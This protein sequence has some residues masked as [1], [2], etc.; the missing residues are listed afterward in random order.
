M[1]S[2][3]EGHAGATG[4][5]DLSTGAAMTV[6]GVARRLGVAPATLRTWDRRYGLGPTDH[7]AGAHRRYSPADVARLEVMR[8]LVIEGAAPVDAA[9]VAL[10]GVAMETPTAPD[11]APGRGGGGQVVP[12][13]GGSAAARGLARA[14]MSLDAPAVAAIV[15]SN[16][17]RRGVIATWDDLL[18]PV[19]KGVGSRFE[20]TGRGVEVEHLLSEAVMAA[21]TEV[22]RRMTRP[23]NHQPVLL[24]A[25]DEEQHTLPLHAVAAA[26]AEQRVASRMLGAR[27]PRGALAAAVRRS[28]PIAVMVWSQ[29]PGD[30]DARRRQLADLPSI[31]PAPLVVVGGP[32]WGDDD[33]PSGVTFVHTLSDAV[34]RLVAA[35]LV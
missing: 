10:A 9:R 20:W 1:S 17:E 31:R 6:A 11:D 7:A 22:T 16:I 29:L 3:S 15:S 32:G 19:L 35:T 12:L 34:S 27:V 4:P 2:S 13:P 25:A 26:L 33:L 5:P 21:L 14:A 8:R 23:R 30:G 18:V 28:G 24:A